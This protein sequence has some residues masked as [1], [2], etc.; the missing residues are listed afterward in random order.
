MKP[1]SEMTAAECEAELERL[2]RLLS[3]RDIARLL[4]VDDR[5]RA[6]TAL[7]MSETG[8]PSLSR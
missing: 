2:S 7:G 4:E 5:R 6:L 3:S 1:V 8:V